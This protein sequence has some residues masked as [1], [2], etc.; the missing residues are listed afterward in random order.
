MAIDPHR[1]FLGPEFLRIYR[2]LTVPSLTAIEPLRAVLQDA[3][4][5]AIGGIDRVWNCALVI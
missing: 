3:G 4:G 2:Q 1:S 5:L